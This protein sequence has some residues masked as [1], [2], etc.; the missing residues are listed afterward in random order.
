[1]FPLGKLPQVNQ[2][3]L[4]DGK[5][6]NIQ[7]IQIMSKVAHSRKGHPL[8]RQLALYILSSYQVPSQDHVSESLAIGDFVKNNVIYRRDPDDIEYLQDPLKLAQDIK[9]GQAT[10]DCDDIATLIAT[11]C[12]SVG[13]KPFYRAVRYEKGFGNFNHIYVV[14]YER[15]WGEP[16]ATRIV[17]D[18]ILKR[19]PIGQ[20]VPHLSGE[21]FE[22]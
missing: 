10:G 13:I 15:N 22:L 7:T 18:G 3:K 1:M 4:S 8:V 17:L 5:K 12:L 2:Y 14:A 11:L 19:D 16:E 6:G 21:E 20:E 9:N